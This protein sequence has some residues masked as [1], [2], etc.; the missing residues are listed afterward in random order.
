MILCWYQVLAEARESATEATKPSESAILDMTT[1][2]ISST[3]LTSTL[4]FPKSP[5]YNNQ[6]EIDLDYLE[7]E[8]HVKVK[9]R[10]LQSNGGFAPGGRHAWKSIMFWKRDTKVRGM[11][12]YVQS[13]AAT[14]VHPSRRTTVYNLS[15]PSTP[16]R[17]SNYRQ[18]GSSGPLYTDDFSKLPPEHWSNRPEFGPVTGL[19]VTMPRKDDCYMSPYIPLNRTERIASGPLYV[20]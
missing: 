15:T 2:P 17:P 4:Y 6:H 3:G 1:M 7:Y 11:Q 12:A 10:E 13:A 19:K 9:A 18:R 20:V 8:R 16:M 14:P 5:S